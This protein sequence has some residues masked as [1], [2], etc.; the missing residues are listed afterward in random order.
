MSAF[1]PSLAISPQIE[2]PCC[3]HYH[4]GLFCKKVGNTCCKKVWWWR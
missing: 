2:A 1:Y 4:K 3:K